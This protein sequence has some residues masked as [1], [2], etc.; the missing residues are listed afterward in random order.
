MTAANYN[1]QTFST[2]TK[3]GDYVAQYRTSA[4]EARKI[5]LTNLPSLTAYAA[6]LRQEETPDEANRQLWRLYTELKEEAAQT[7]DNA[8][9]IFLP[10]GNPAETRTAIL[11]DYTKAVLVAI[12]DPAERGEA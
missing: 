10:I 9:K 11:A 2:I 4:Q 7:I 6:D 12:A 5:P 1:P 3:L 8:F